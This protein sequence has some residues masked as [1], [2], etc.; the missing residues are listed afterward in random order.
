MKKSFMMRGFATGKANMAGKIVLPAEDHRFDCGDLVITVCITDMADNTTEIVENTS[1]DTTEPD[2]DIETE[3]EANDAGWY[4]DDIT[5]KTTAYD[6]TS[7]IESVT[8]T[9]TAPDGTI[10]GGAD[11]PVE[12]KDFKRE[13]KCTRYDSDKKIR[14]PDV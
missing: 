7:G 8:Y 2:A 9:I 11:R 4:N 13:T 12:L 3:T 1:I 6:A 10:I 14:Q 5:F